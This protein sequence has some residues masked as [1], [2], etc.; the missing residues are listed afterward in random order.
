MVGMRKGGER[1]ASVAKTIE[2][3]LTFSCHL[4]EAGEIPENNRKWWKEGERR[5]AKSRN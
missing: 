5:R 3:I 2:I 1:V 4:S